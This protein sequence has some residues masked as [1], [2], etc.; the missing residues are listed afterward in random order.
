MAGGTQRSK[1]AP[2]KQRVALPTA[3][4]LILLTI[5]LTFSSSPTAAATGWEV[6]L[7]RPTPRFQGMDFVSNDEGWLVAGGGLLHTTDGGATWEEAA[8]ITAVDIDFA[9]AAHGWAVGYNG[10]IFA[11]ADGGETWSKQDSGTNVHLRDVFALSA[12]EAFTAGSNIGFSDIADPNPPLAFLHTADGGATWEQV[13]VPNR[14]R[15]SEITFLGDTGWAAGRRC[16]T[17]RGCV[18]DPIILRTSDRGATWTELTL[19]ESIPGL[20]SMTFLDEMNGWAV[21]SHCIRQ[22]CSWSIWHTSDGGETWN[23]SETAPADAIELVV[24]SHTDAWA[25]TRDCN[26]GS[27]G[28]KFSLYGTSDGGETWEK[29]NIPEGL[30]SVASLDATNAA[31]YVPNLMV[32][33]LD[34]GVN[35]QPMQ[36]PA[37]Y[38]SRI[39]FA[40]ADV[41]YGSFFGGQ[42]FRTE[43]G[44]RN[45]SLLE[46]PLGR[47][48]EVVALNRDVVIVVGSGDVAGSSMSGVFRTDDGGATWRLTHALNPQLTTFVQEVEF[49]DDRHGWIALYGGVAFT[50][51]GGETWRERVFNVRVEA[52]DMAGA[53]DVWIIVPELSNPQSYRLIHSTDGGFTWEDV[54]PGGI[55]RPQHLEFVDADHGWYTDVLCAESECNRVL[56]ATSDGGTTWQ[57]HV[58]ESGAAGASD[59]T[60]VDP[61]NGW[62]SSWSCSG[63]AC[64]SRALHTEDSGHTWQVQLPEPGT[65]SEE[66]Y[67]GTFDFIDAETGWF[68]LNPSRGQGIGGGPPPRMVIYRTTDGGGPIGEDPS[69]TPTPTVQ[70]PKV[71]TN[72]PADDGSSTLPSALLLSGFVLAL[73][74]V[75]LTLLKKRSA[76]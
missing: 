17:D 19:A 72:G 6:V 4:A 69:P 33:S 35:W 67:A 53:N 46:T 32:R 73:G 39:D 13:D 71:G 60:F 63:T 49:V 10:S 47:G 75:G 45:W 76:A 12:T 58:I 74:A 11:T 30:T 42:M 51:D 68:V 34:G 7:D 38:L 24:P 37:M 18:S 29:R 44:G 2:I 52:A 22:P 23:E 1:T 43:D 64:S 16:T 40:D 62:I 5:G 65:V 48:E 9:D 15:V 26:T 55:E 66:I 56:F 70:L 61:M 36:H 41:G 21:S 8:K 3:L 28:C 27:S 31:L 57:E 54:V 50:D 14:T 25:I 20:A 59:L